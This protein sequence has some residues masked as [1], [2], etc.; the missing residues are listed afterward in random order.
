MCFSP[1]WSKVH[2]EPQG[3][4]PQAVATVAAATPAGQWCLPPTVATQAGLQ[5]TAVVAYPQ[6]QQPRRRR[7]RRRRQGQELAPEARPQEPRQGLA[8]RRRHPAPCPSPPRPR[9]AARRLPPLPAAL[10]SAPGQRT[11]PAPAAVAAVAVAAVAVAVA[12]AVRPGSRWSS[13]PAQRVRFLTRGAW[14]GAPCAKAGGRGRRTATGPP[15]AQGRARRKSARE[16]RCV[17]VSWWALCR[18]CVA[19]AR[20]GCVDVGVLLPAPCL[21]RVHCVR[22]L[23]FFA[24]V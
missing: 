21:C 5:L 24:S 17:R 8:L 7:R 9:R 20:G 4:D 6:R 19:R 2:Q 3:P 11:A 18:V 15:P 14:I 1:V 10:R 13:G 23:I 16:R 22:L 12:V